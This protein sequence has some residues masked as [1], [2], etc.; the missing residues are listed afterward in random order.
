[1]LALDSEP[2]DL[3]L[4]V[5]EDGKALA[6]A[7]STESLLEVSV[8]NHGPT[9]DTDAQDLGSHMAFYYLLL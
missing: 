3:R 6:T 1:M 7:L 4:L 8:I 5:V 9:Q 2:V